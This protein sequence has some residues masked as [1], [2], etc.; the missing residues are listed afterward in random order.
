MHRNDHRGKG[1]DATNHPEKSKPT[2]I[3]RKEFDKARKQYWKEQY[4][5]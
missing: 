4:P 3:E 5:Q 2:Q 1:N